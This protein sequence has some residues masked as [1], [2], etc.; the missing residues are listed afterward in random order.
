[1]ATSMELSKVYKLSTPPLRMFYMQ[2]HEEGCFVC[3]SV[4]RNLISR[5][6]EL[7]KAEVNIYIG[8]FERRVR[9]DVMLSP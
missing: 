2:Y 9:I 7:F 4:V 5:L 3:G 1:M 6:I 8:F